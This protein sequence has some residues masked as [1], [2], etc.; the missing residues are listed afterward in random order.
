MVVGRVVRTAEAGRRR[1]R[2]CRTTWA[3]G[4]DRCSC[5]S[6]SRSRTPA[7]WSRPAVDRDAVAG[8]LARRRA[9]AAGRRRRRVRVAARPARRR[10]AAAVAACRNDGTFP[11][12]VGPRAMTRSCCRRRSSSTTTRRWPPR[13]RATSATPPRSTRS[14]PCACS[15]SPTRRRPRPA[16]PT[17]APRPSSTGA[18]TCRPR[19]GSACTGASLRLGT[20]SATRRTPTDGRSAEALPW[21]E[22]GGRRRRRPLDRHQWVGGVEV[23]KGTTVRLRPSR[24][25][26]AQDLFLAGRTA[27]VAGVFRDVDGDE[28]L[29]VTL[30]DDPAAELFEWQRPLP[31]LP[32]RRGRGAGMTP[33]RPNVLVA[34][35]GNIFLGDDGFGV[36]VANRLAGCG[37]ARRAFGSRTSASGASTSPTS[38]STATTP[39]SSS[40]PCPWASRRARSPSSSPRWP[41]PADATPDRRR[42]TDVD[43]HSMNPALVLGDAGRPGRRGR[44]GARRRLPAGGRSTRASVCRRRGRRRRPGGG[45]RRRRAR[46]AVRRRTRRGAGS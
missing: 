40:T 41:P 16:A 1:G 31:L 9:H 38:C 12:L 3:D 39:S 20:R 24:R 5:R 35:I 37:R 44:A 2:A 43:A 11:V 46:R 8:P 13:A 30:D 27:T 23:G 14:W 25:A 29:A 22:P 36:E 18:T 6:P 17:P 34:G 4:P 19:S 42:C 26:D 32:P 33:V 28:H 10:A 21:W 7:G 15:R 45:R